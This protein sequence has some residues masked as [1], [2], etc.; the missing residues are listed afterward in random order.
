MHL[1]TLL[2]PALVA[3]TLVLG[4]SAW[5]Q[6]RTDAAPSPPT[7]PPDGG[8]VPD[9]GAPAPAEP[10]DAGSDAGPTR[11]EE[12]AEIAAELERMKPSGGSSNADA[13]PPAS[14]VASHESSGAS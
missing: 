5:A 14:P 10:A 4:A 2:H 3:C 8:T 9:A 6:Q 7:N 12:E 11:A 1:R 13:A